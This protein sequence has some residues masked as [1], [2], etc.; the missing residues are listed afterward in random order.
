M[1][2]GKPPKTRDANFSPMRKPTFLEKKLGW[3]VDNPDCRLAGPQKP[4]P[5]IYTPIELCMTARLTVHELHG[6]VITASEGRIHHFRILQC[7]RNRAVTKQLLELHY[8]HPSICQLCREC[9]T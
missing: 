9:M 1:G 6:S 3:D 7:S 2:L 4:G 8:V 5:G